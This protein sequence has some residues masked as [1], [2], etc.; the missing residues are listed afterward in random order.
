MDEALAY[1]VHGQLRLLLKA[2]DRHEAHLES[3]HRFTDGG[4]VGRVVL[5]TLARQPVR[6]DKLRRDELEGVAMLHK[7]PRPMVSAW[8]QASMPMVQGGR[9][10]INS[11]SLARALLGRTS[12]GLPAWL[13]PCTAKTFLAR[14][15]PT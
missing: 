9:V 12:S 10:A 4:G 6:D 2:L 11:C 13:T 15:M 1:P 5:A 3:V 7:Q 14:S 8:S